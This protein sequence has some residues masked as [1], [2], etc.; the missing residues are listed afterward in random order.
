MISRTI[1]QVKHSERN[2]NMDFGLNIRKEIKIT[3]WVNRFEIM[4]AA[5]LSGVSFRVKTLMS[6]LDN[7]SCGV[8]IL[9]WR[10]QRKRGLQK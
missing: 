6:P 4:C 7:S 2:M 1:S 8:P 5:N 3:F 9:Y 10:L